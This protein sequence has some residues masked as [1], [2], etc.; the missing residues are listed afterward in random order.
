MLQL[1]YLQTQYRHLPPQ[2]S[3]E[4]LASRRTK[5]GGSEI[6]ACIGQCPYQKPAQL[7]ANKKEMKPIRA[8]PCTFGHLFEPLAKKLIENSLDTQVYE[9]GAV[10]STRFPVCYSPDG[11]LVVD[12][13]LKLLEIKCPFRRHK[14]AT[15]PGHYV[16]QVKTGMEI[17]PTE[18]CYFYQFRFRICRISQLGGSQDYNRWLHLESAKRCPPVP[19]I[20]WG[21]IHFPDKIPLWDLGDLSKERAD[22][23]CDFQRRS[24]DVIWENLEMPDRGYVLPFKLFDMTLAKIPRDVGFLDRNASSIWDMH[25]SLV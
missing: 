6:A 18:E 20:T 22:E 17:L 12:D 13:T 24:S 15:V 8:A 14:L 7:T 19:P 23:L 25:Q 1:K 9:L 2:G 10:P 11:L 16:C 21:F 4:W 5:V 3:S